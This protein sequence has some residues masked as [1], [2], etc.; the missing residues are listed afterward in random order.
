MWVRIPLAALLQLGKCQRLKLL[1]TS[2]PRPVGACRIYWSFRKP[3]YPRWLFYFSPL[4]LWYF[5]LWKNTAISPPRVGEAGWGCCFY[6]PRSPNV[7]V[8]KVIEL[9]PISIVAGG[10]VYRVS[11]VCFMPRSQVTDTA[12]A[13]ALPP[14]A[15]P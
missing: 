1:V 9:T 12:R 4:C 8:E 2:I 11:C 15:R 10:A 5:P 13:P 6:S 3:P 7:G 14:A